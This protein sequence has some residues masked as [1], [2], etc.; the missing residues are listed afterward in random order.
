M[1]KKHIIGGLFL[2]LHIVPGICGVIGAVLLGISF[3]DKVKV[4]YGD[5][6]IPQGVPFGLMFGYIAVFATFFLA[7]FVFPKTRLWKYMEK[8]YNETTWEIKAK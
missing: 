3:G 2:A 7:V 4:R 6:V 5:I 8:M 1:F